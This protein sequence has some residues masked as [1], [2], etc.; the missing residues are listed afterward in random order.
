MI[1]LCEHWFITKQQLMSPEPSLI[2][3]QQRFRNGVLVQNVLTP[4]VAAARNHQTAEMLAKTA[5]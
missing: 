2:L 3:G 5:S 4:N 1:P